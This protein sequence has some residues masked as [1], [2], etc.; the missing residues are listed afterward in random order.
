MDITESTKF[1]L[2]TDQ[3]KLDVTLPVGTHVLKLTVF[4]DA[5]LASRSDTVVVRVKPKSNPPDAIAIVPAAAAQGATVSATIYGKDLEGVTAVAAYLDGQLDD[6]IAITVRPGGTTEQLPI[7][8]RILEHAPLGLRTLEVTAPTGIDAVDFEVLPRVKPEPSSIEP[9]SGYVGNSKPR[10]VT[11]KGENLDQA[12]AATFL[13]RNVPDNQLRAAI[14][15]SGPD[16]V[17]LDLSISANAEFGTRRFAVTTPNGTGSSPPEATFRVVPGTLQIGII[18][19]TLA[20]ALAHLLLRIPPTLFALDSVGYLLLLAGMYLPL[21]GMATARPWLR[22]ILLLYAVINIF[23]RIVLGLNQELITFVAPLIEV[24]L[25]V[26]L[27][28]ESQSPQW[29]DS[30]QS[31]GI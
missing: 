26:L 22:W 11:I 24:V 3:P 20:A 27:F 18:A 19:A 25:A 14:Q 12:V 31:D 10:A 13:L 21:P 29:R 1:P 2:D 9:V 8:M 6:R 28:A 23:S 17:W 4:D 30:A 5:G 16:G 15:R 7:Q